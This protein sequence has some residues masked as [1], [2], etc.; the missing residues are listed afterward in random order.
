MW[1]GIGLG[2]AVSGLNG[3]G[4]WLFLRWAFSKKSTLFMQIFFGGMVGRLM[5]VS[6]ISLLL[7]EYTPVHRMAYAGSLMVCYLFF[8][9][10][11]VVF[12]HQKA[13][14]ERAHRIENIPLKN[15]DP[16]KG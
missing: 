14:K 15:N 2:A 3:L 7:L 9:I 1:E 10:A 5:L 13:K 8:L 16:R 11:E 12:I 6:A 4:A